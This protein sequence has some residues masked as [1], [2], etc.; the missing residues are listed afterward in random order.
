[1]KTYSAQIAL[2]NKERDSQ[3]RGNEHGMFVEYLAKNEIDA[4]KGAKRFADR[5]VAQNSD[6]WTQVNCIKVMYWTAQVMDDK[7]YCGLN[8][9]CNLFEWKC[10]YPGTFEQ[11]LSSAEARAKQY[12]KEE[13]QE[14]RKNK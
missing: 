1:M 12:R 7:G 11:W 3:G 8:R 9:G 14:K 5:M 10:D 13:R 2:Q 6:R 4:A